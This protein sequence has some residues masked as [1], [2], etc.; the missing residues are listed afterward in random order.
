MK[1]YLK[2]SGLD[3]RL[4]PNDTAEFTGIPNEIV[5]VDGDS[6]LKLIP[7]EKEDMDKASEAQRLAERDRHCRNH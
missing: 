3:E 6:G 7:F 1:Y 5:T 2:L 4:V